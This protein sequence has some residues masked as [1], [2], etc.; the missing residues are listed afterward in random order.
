MSEQTTPNPDEQSNPPTEGTPTGGDTEG[1]PSEGA[2][3]GID[4]TASQEE[5]DAAKQKARD[6]D[7]ERLAEESQ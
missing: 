7:A 3:E 6:A 2:P 1:Q 5:I 4:Y